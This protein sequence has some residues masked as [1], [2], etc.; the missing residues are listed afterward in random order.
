MSLSW[1]RTRDPLRPPVSPS[2][3]D[4]ST[5]GALTDLIPATQFIDAGV[6]RHIGTYS[7]A[8]AILAGATQVVLSG[9]PGQRP[10]G[11]RPEDFADEA[12]Q[13]CDNVRGAAVRGREAER[14]RSGRSW[15]TSPGDIDTYV[16]ARKGIL[17]YRPA[18]M[19]A[20]VAQL[21]WPS[22]RLEIEVTAVVTHPAANQDE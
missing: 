1:K 11:T 5:R 7:D 4:P 12:R 19:L 8:V 9:T 2:R 14:H 17:F 3:T 10:G 13:A 21:I 15:L 20:V 18:Y 22:L 16:K 6:S